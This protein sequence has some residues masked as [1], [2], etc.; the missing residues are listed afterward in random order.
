MSRLGT[1]PWNLLMAAST[2]MVVPVLLLFLLAQRSFIEGIST[3]GVK[4]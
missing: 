1:T 4:G 3:S 2:I